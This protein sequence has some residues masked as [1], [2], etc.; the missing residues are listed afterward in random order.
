[1]WYD[2]RLY[3]VGFG[4]LSTYVKAVSSAS[5]THIIIILGL[6]MQ[7]YFPFRGFWEIIGLSGAKWTTRNDDDVLPVSITNF[8]NDR[9]TS[10]ML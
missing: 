4:L 10:Q 3:C 5:L 8:M 7:L 9:Q 1:M 6:S 2:Y